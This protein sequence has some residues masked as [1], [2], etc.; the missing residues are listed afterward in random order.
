MLDMFAYKINCIVENVTVTAARQ[1]D[2]RKALA[3]PS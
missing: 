1:S 2:C 3:V